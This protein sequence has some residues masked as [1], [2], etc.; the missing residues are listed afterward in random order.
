MDLRIGSFR[1]RLSNDAIAAAPAAAPISAVAPSPAAT[2]ASDGAK[3]E[4]SEIEE[5]QI[6]V[7]APSLGRFW[8][9]PKPTEP[10]FVEI[11]ANVE[12]G[13]VVCIVEVMKLFTQVKAEV[14]GKIISCPLTDGEM[15]EYDDV[16]F[17]IQP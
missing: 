16:L 4:S 5:G 8:R 7:R 15:V 14:A 11:G 10:P 9:K 3:R 2:P 1:L 13:E 17:V 6:A 12:A